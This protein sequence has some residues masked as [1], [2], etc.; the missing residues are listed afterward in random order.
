M[1][2]ALGRDRDH[3]HFKGAALP[4]TVTLAASDAWSFDPAPTIEACAA[5]K[6]ALCLACPDDSNVARHFRRPWASVYRG[7]AAG[8]YIYHEPQ[9]EN[10]GLGAAA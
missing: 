8:V 7:N 1:R 2:R 3:V 5:K 10:L 9:R 4:I 6:Q